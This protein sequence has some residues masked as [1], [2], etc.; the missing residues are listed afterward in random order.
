MRVFYVLVLMY[1]L[2]CISQVI[3]IH[4]GAQ[5]ISTCA[6]SDSVLT[7]FVQKDLHFEAALLLSKALATARSHYPGMHCVY[8]KSHQKRA[9][10][11]IAYQQNSQDPLCRL[12]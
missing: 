1:S 4:E 11:L 5:V 3:S 8:T 9:G 12:L 2:G 10:V 6:E 7:V